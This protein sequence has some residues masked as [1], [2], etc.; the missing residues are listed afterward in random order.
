MQ[1]YDVPDDDGGNDV[2]NP[3]PKPKA[4]AKPTPQRVSKSNDD[5]LKA[6]SRIRELEIEV[7]EK[8]KKNQQNQFDLENVTEELKTQAKKLNFFESKF[9]SKGK[10]FFDEINDEWKE[11]NRE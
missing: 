6:E 9:K 11:L 10:N 4:K 7:S 2:L 8:E 5:L 3:D 1:F